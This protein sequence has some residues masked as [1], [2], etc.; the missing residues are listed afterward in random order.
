MSERLYVGTRKGLFELRRNAA[1]QWLPMASHF[2]GEP[3]SMLLADPRD[4]ALYAAL[5][6]GHFGVKLWRRDAGATDWKECAVPVYPPQ[7]PAA[8]P[9][10]GQAA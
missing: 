6:L 2:L 3:L 4:G 10:E 5:N 1:G 7:P 9:L 8:E